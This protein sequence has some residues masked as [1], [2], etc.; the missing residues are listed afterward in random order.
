MKGGKAGASASERANPRQWVRRPERQ[1]ARGR[2][3][4]HQ[5]RQVKVAVQPGR[6]DP[7]EHQLLQTALKVGIV[8]FPGQALRRTVVHVEEA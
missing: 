6:L 1:E 4:A 7:A 5:A 2:V 3:V 8:T